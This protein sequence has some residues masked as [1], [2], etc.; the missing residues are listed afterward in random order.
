MNATEHRGDDAAPS[1]AEVLRDSYVRR[2]VLTQLATSI[3]VFL[4]VAVLA[5]QLYDITDD[6][7][8]LGLL[9]LVE[10][11]PAAFLVLITGSVADRFDRRF[12]AA[13]GMFG[14]VVSTAALLL[15][16]STDPDQAWP[17]YV[18]AFGYGA[19]RAFYSPAVR[20]MPPMLAP[21]HGL[22]RTIALSSSVFTIAFIIGPG[23]SGFLYTI[24]P[25]V[26]YGVALALQVA[27]LVGVF[28]LRFRRE[29]ARPGPNDRPSLHSALE[30][31][32]FIRRTPML[33]AAISLDL[34][35]VLFGGA[36]ALLPAIAEDRLGVGDIAYGWLRASIGIGAGL[37]ALVFT[38]R[39]VQ[40]HVGKVLY[41]VIAL[42]GV[43]TIVLG[44]T[45]NYV[46]AFMALAVLSG[47]DMVSVFIRSTLVP[48]ITPDDK[49]GRV[50]AVEMV[51]IGASNELGGFESGVAAALMGT[52]AA[53]VS[54]GAA[55]LVIVALWWVF[56]PSLRDVD[57]F[58]D[59][60]PP[61]P[62]PD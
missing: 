16:A 40:R 35:A 42:F 24:D 48:L 28:F 5:K 14:Q 38:I 41:G 1:L 15:Y 12:V 45:R 50:F 60:H 18:M 51:C 62:R 7:F 58:A 17:L 2:F 20:S 47:A 33:L 55:T 6:T 29:P 46:V 57:R 36:V 56:F 23:A 31:L 27:G 52:A 13:A 49:R 53:V 8:S 9:G 61:P 32:R 4:Q 44:L 37:T 54:G 11:A 10:F 30:G 19:S 22:P 34:F 39:P 59:L 43:A 25:A 26:A 21:E 3:G